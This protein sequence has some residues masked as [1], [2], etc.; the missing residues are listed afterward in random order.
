MVCVT[1]LQARFIAQPNGACGVR[2]R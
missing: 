1:A 2:R